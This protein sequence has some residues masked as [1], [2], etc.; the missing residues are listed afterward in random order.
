MLFSK[1]LKKSKLIWIFF[2]EGLYINFGLGWYF[3]IIY[4]S[5]KISVNHKELN[6]KYFINLSGLLC[7]NQLITFDW[8]LF[9]S[10][11]SNFNNFFKI[12]WD[13]INIDA[14]WFG[15]LVD[16]I[17]ENLGLSKITGGKFIFYSFILFK[18]IQKL[19]IIIIFD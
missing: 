14:Y 9:F 11:V 15:W 12:F 10:F 16:N 13:S 4:I 19:I 2:V 17:E 1:R 18:S 3:A 6:E 8:K 7:F 5:F